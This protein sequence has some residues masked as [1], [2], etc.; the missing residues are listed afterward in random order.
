M[1][2]LS[3]TDDITY[4]NVYANYIHR[5]FEITTIVI[6][7]TRGNTVKASAYHITNNTTMFIIYILVI[8]VIYERTIKTYTYSHE[9]PL[10]LTGL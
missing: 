6:L 2:Q 9:M 10:N 1:H 3:S 4:A 8:A 7:A 5:H